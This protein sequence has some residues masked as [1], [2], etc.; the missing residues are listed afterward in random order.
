MILFYTNLFSVD[1]Q[2]MRYTVFCLPYTYVSQVGAKM[3]K[4]VALIA[5][6]YH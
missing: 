3:M 2:S 1:H 5:I 4:I 6:Y